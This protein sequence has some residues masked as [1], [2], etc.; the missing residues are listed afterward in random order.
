MR[1]R[2]NHGSSTTSLLLS[3]AFALGCTNGQAPDKPASGGPA[4]PAKTA[5]ST[6]PTPVPTPA[7]ETYDLRG[8]P[9][10]GA[11]RRTEMT[12]EVQDAQLSM[13]VGELAVAGTMSLKSQI[14]EDLE[15]QEVGDG[16]V[17]KGRLSH[18]LQK[19]TTTTR[20]KL[21][22]GSEE[23]NPTEENGPLHGRVETVEFSGG[24]WKR[25]LEGPPPTPE[26]AR[27]LNG[28]PFEGETYPTAI[29][30]GDSWTET[31]PELRRWLGSDVLSVRGEVKNTLLAVELQQGEKVA[32]IES[33]GEIEA[34]M[35]DA[36]NREMKM[37][38]GLQGKMR[39]SLDKAVDLEG[40]AEGAIKLSGDI[41]QDGVSMSMSIT[42]RF[43]GKIRGS[44]R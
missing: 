21:P 8:A 34:T 13:K 17:R 20:V 25:T 35:V 10:Q 36:D 11:T 4:A 31:G 6:T 5:P 32:V 29:K 16:T 22:N 18:V 28:S 41:V 42:G 44:L 39:R 23:S 24:Q 2:P 38:M 30:V 37:T 33:L 12:F 14:T 9:V 26:Q 1:T 43:T 40:S 19:S 3:V 15:I 27:L 7:A